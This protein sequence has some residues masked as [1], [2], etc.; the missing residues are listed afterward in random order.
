MKS[1]DLKREK[2]NVTFDYQNRVKKDPE[3]KKVKRIIGSARVLGRLCSPR[4][5]EKR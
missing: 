3:K 5:P 2:K 1:I 4:L